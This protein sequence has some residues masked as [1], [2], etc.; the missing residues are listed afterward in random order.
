MA[1]VGSGSLT[2]RL[3]RKSCGRADPG[4][5]FATGEFGGYAMTDNSDLHRVNRF[6][7]T[8][9]PESDPVPSGEDI[10]H[11]QQ[12]GRETPRRYDEPVDQTKEGSE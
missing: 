8:D 4:T 11:R 12:E 9:T 6:D 1:F 2:A 10:V 7:P 3:Y 5:R